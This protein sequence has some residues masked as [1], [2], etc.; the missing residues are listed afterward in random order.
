[1]LDV[2]RGVPAVVVCHLLGH[3]L[4][5]GCPIRRLRRIDHL[6]VLERGLHYR[7]LFRVWIGNICVRIFHFGVFHSGSLGGYVPV[8]LYTI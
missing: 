3:V 2:G 6:R 4:D 5:H 1:M 7:V 8:A